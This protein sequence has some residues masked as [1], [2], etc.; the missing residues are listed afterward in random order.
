MA[1]I[2]ERVMA[3]DAVYGAMVFEFFSSGVPAIF[4]HAGCEYLIYDMEHNGAG[5]ETLKTQA[6]ICRGLPVVPMARVP[7]SAYH[8]LARALDIGM[9]GVMVP[10]VESGEQARAIAEATRYPPVGRRGAAFGF[11]HD[12]YSGGAPADKI[13]AANAEITVIAQIETERGLENVEEIAQVAGIDVLWVGQ[14]DLTNFLGIPG[15][16]EHPAF[17]DAV[18]RTVAAAR[19]NG[20]GLGFLATDEV[21][22]ARAREMGFN[23]VAVGTDQGLLMRGVA[24]VL[25][26]ARQA[27]GK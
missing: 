11:A 25:E 13:A 27:D 3:G 20:K 22:A 21:W 15:D 6:A 19:R 17:R 26:A 8:F 10:M 14:F 23:M 1:G 18:A 24:S 4:A 2:R 12:G 9:R 7:A 5:F 16:F